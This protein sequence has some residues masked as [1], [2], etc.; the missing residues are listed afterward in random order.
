MASSMRCSCAAA[1]PLDPQR[2][3]AALALDHRRALPHQSGEA[4][5]IDRRRHHHDAQVLAQHR[6]ALERQ[7][8]A[9]VAVEVAL[10]RLVEQHRRDARQLL[11]AEDLR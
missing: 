2:M 10:V 5:A 6:A 8:Q 4:R 9:E 7:R 1:E 3:R 11:V